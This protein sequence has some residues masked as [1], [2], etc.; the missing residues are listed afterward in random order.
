MRSPFFVCGL[1]VLGGCAAKTSAPVAVAASPQIKTHTAPPLRKPASS[2][3]GLAAL[4]WHKI[5][6]GP[7]SYT[8]TTP[9]K[10]A[11]Q[12]AFLKARNANVMRLEDAVR[13]AKEGK[14]LPPRAVALGFDDGFKSC[15]TRVFPLLKKYNWPAT[16][17]IYPDWISSG[18]DSL[19]WD[20]VR[21]MQKSG[22]VDV[23][24]HSMGH[25]NLVLMGA[26]NGRSYAQRLQHEITGSKRTIEEKLGTKVTQ[27]AFPFGFYDETVLAAVRR[28]GYDS[29][30]TVNAS[31]FRAQFAGG[32]T[33]FTLPRYL[34]FRNDSM[35]TFARYAFSSPLKVSR[36]SPAPNVTQP[37][38]V[39]TISAQLDEDVDPRS[40]QMRLAIIQ[41][42]KATFNPQTRVVSYKPRAALH[43]GVWTVSISAIDRRGQSK[44][45]SWAF[46]VR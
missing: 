30:W 26:K 9:E 44:A 46:V 42:V 2:E 1:V 11:A 19:T 23:Q 43:K 32:E 40:V 5:A 27:L 21:A 3:N 33:W 24:S 7:D 8:V 29:S 35:A 34:V 38:R 25:P 18:G 10:F 6:Q 22:L 20:E 41:N 28:A 14:P 13:L 37:N 39:P 16:L 45:A 36:L 17:Y 15:Y 31:P 4:T 12:L